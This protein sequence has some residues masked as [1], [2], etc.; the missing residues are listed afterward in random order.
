MPLSSL[1]LT[2]VLYDDSS[3]LS[4]AMALITLSPILLMASYAAL[5]I[6]WREI[7]VINMWAGQFCCEALNLVIK[8]LLKQ[9]RP[10]GSVGNGYGFPSSH[11]QYMGYF[12]TFLILHFH[13]RHKISTN[14]YWMTDKTLRTSVY[15]II[16]TW[17][18]T[19]AYSRYYLSYH[20]ISQILWGVCIGI[21]FG[22]SFYVVAE[23]LPTRRPNSLLGRARTLLLRNPVF[24][25]LRIRDGWAVWPDGGLE[26]EWQRWDREWR[27]RTKA[28]L[29][30]N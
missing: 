16:V 14:G 5:A 18:V 11:S 20:S 19:V 7:T 3:H 6:F 2:H 22:G 9:G 26:E 12:A 23:L 17:A 1:E 25:W 21:S 13:F 10:P 28:R 29:H 27:G 15:S 4:L 30:L 24:M 8:R